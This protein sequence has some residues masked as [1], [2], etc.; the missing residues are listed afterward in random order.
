MASNFSGGA[1]VANKAVSKLKNNIEA[2]AES[3]RCAVKEIQDTWKAQDMSDIPITRWNENKGQYKEETPREPVQARYDTPEEMNARI[4]AVEQY[5][6]SVAGAEKETNKLKTAID[7]LKAE[8][9]EMEKT[10]KWWGDDEYDEAAIK[11]EELSQEAKELRKNTL[12]ATTEVENPFGL[13]TLAGKIKE[14]ELELKNL[15]K[16]GKGLGSQDYDKAFQNLSKLKAEEK[17]Y[18]RNLTGVADAEREASKLKA[19]A[20]AEK[21]AL[22]DRNKQ[23]SEGRKRASKYQQVINQISNSIKSIGKAAK[24]A[25]LKIKKMYAAMGK[26][27]QIGKLNGSKNTS[28]NF[29]DTLKTILK[30]T[31]GIR[32]LYV[33]ANK[34]RNA[35]ADGFKNLA[36]YSNATNSNISSI[37]SSLTT[38]KNALAT[39]FNPILTVVSPILTKFIDMLSDAT[40]YV[41]MFF[42]RLTGQDYFTKAK[43]VNINYADSL[44]K[45]AESAKD[46]TKALDDY[47]SPIDEL[48]KYSSS[49]TENTPAVS[50]TTPNSSDMFETVPISDSLKNMVDK[51]KKY[52]KSEDW[53]GLGKYVANGINKGLKKIYNT[54]KWSNVGPRITKFCD[55]FTDS[56]NSIADNINW[57]LLGRTIGTGINTIVN[58]LDLLI[59]GI[60]WKS[61]GKKFAKGIEGFV[62]ETEWT[63]LGKMLGHKFMIAWDIFGGIVHNLPYTDIG[64]SFAEM[65]NGAFSSVSFSQI[66]DTLATGLNGAFKTL[67][68][69][70]VNFEW[71]DL[72][73][74]IVSGINTFIR[75]FEWTKNGKTLEEFLDKLCNSLVEFAHN[76]NWEEFGK[77]VGNMLAEVDWSEHLR[78]VVDVIKTT[79]GKLFDGLEESGTAGKIVAFLGKAFIAAKALDILG[80]KPLITKIVSHIAAKL[81][82]KENITNVANAIKELF[83]GSTAEAAAE[84]ETMM[85]GLGA[86][87]ETGASGF[88][89][90]TT[91]VAPWIGAAGL[92]ATLAIGI[93]E[94]A[95]SISELIDSANGGNGRITDFGY[96]ID[97]LIRIMQ[98]SNAITAD[99]KQ[100]LF[101]LKE[102]LEDTDAS[103]DEYGTTLADA[104][105]KGNVSLQDLQVAITQ[106]KTD[107]NLT[108]EETDMLTSL[109][110]QLGQK[111]QENAGITT[112]AATISKEQWKSMKETLS[113]LT[114]EGVIPFSD[115]L[116]TLSG[117]LMEQESYGATAEEAY[118]KMK[119]AMENMGMTTESITEV[120]NELFPNATASVKTS[121]D[122]NIVAAQE[123]ITNSMETAQ[124]DVEKAMKNMAEDTQTN[125]G[126]IK[127][128]TDD[129]FKG[130]SKSSST[131]WEASYDAVKKALDGMKTDTLQAMKDVMGY[132]Q[133][134]WKSVVLDTNSTWELM[135]RK[136]GKELNSMA[137]S[138]NVQGKVVANNLVNAIR[139]AENSILRIFNNIVSKANGMISNINSS[140]S[141]IERGFTFTYNYTNP[142]DHTA[143]TYRSWLNLP[144]VNTIPY[145]ASGAVIPPR[146]EFLAVLGDQ[147]KGNNIEAPENLIRKIVREETGNS[148]KNGQ[149]VYRVSA[150]VA[151]RTLLD[152][153]IDEAELRRNRNGKNPFD[154]D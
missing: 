108:E 121:V 123:Q 135:S 100:E 17:E 39:A 42:A 7:K 137:N 140:I 97:N 73:D 66:G 143:H 96:T 112:E 131:E 85:D 28:Q 148:N 139:G 83:G 124:T 50:D 132:I 15:E 4:Q 62:N 54:I 133:S 3:T 74:D 114:A 70:T 13:D 79:I 78:Q 61:L 87:A 116:T 81:L 122:T 146:S 106:L 52:I 107:M 111:T 80:I 84:A 141:G 90:L 1:G 128:D 9:K 104:M 57:G 93:A 136:V 149:S 26:L 145:L 69:F 142:F 113:L 86:A 76:T 99:Q 40:T 34:L 63:N 29:T 35:A 119:K 88:E 115:Q 46:A 58:T 8:M 153:I 118:D 18:K 103:A 11:L 36:Q 92:C 23:I 72:V 60:K 21:K 43:K 129:S 67:H 12:Y 49:Q 89:A 105:S 98:N 91:A 19:A 102:Q 37:V 33:L 48:N 64:N 71:T 138:A 109:I 22:S 5:T 117:V 24:S 6:S 101:L 151:G 152:I 41:G 45:T 94:I 32:S 75:K 125:T 16:T 31:L 25:V 134:Y 77:G 44:E 130:V 51:L 144:R 147:K 120:L 82:T 95:E 150:N 53:K 30:Y 56:F 127:K 47:L 20:E 2:T 55:A 68:N 154:L 65:L 59:A 10:G 110:E 27:R 14:A 38:L 126:S